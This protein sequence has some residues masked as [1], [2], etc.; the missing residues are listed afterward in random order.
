MIALT[1]S[2]STLVVSSPTNGLK[3]TTSRPAANVSGYCPPCPNIGARPAFFVHYRALK[4]ARKDDLSIS[5]GA[6]LPFPPSYGSPSD[7][8]TNDTT[9]IASLPG[10]SPSI[11]TVATAIYRAVLTVL[12]LFNVNF[13]WRIH[14]K[15][16]YSKIP[17]D[18]HIMYVHSTQCR[19]P[20]SRSSRSHSYSQKTISSVSHDEPNPR[21]MDEPPCNAAF[22]DA[23]PMRYP[24]SIPSI[25][26]PDQQA[27]KSRS[28][29]QSYWDHCH[30][31]RESIPYHMLYRY[32]Y[33]VMILR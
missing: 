31:L 26:K 9:G 14:G 16:P 17:I 28:T 30:Q 13:T 3:S 15:S 6:S 32:R 12:T 2:S 20:S 24:T 19:S 21:I 4:R 5:P 1:S 29:H 33:A 10:R 11:E 18:W 8:T 27:P 23:L 25:H 7:N 22:N